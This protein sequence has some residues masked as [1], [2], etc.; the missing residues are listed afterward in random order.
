M[1]P[2]QD[3]RG[4][5]RMS[6]E[7]G[8]RA[9]FMRIFILDDE[10]AIRQLIRTACRGSVCEVHEFSRVDAAAAACVAGH[11][12]L[13]FLDL[14]LG[15]GDAIEA[16]RAF[17]EQGYAGP[18]QLMSGSGG[19]VLE[20][21]RRVGLSY[22]FDLLAPLEKPFR[23]VNIRGALA[24]LSRSSEVRIGISPQQDSQPRPTVNSVSL[25]EALDGGWLELWY[26]PKVDLRSGDIVG[27]EGLIRARH[28]DRGT[29]APAQFLP[30][31]TDSALK[32]LTELVI[33]GALRDWV[34]LNAAGWSL[35]LCVNTPPEA[36]LTLPIAE[37]LRRNRPQQP[38]WPGLILELTEDQA[39]QSI[40][41]AREIAAQLRI[42]KV[43]LS[44]DDF[45]Q[46]HSSLARLTEL[47]FESLKIDRAF[48][49]KCGTDPV[50]T[51]LCRTI[52]ELAHRFG[53]RVVAEGIETATELNA[54]RALGCDLGQGYLLG[55]P[56]PICNLISHLRDAR[57]VAGFLG[58]SVRPLAA[59][60]AFAS[61]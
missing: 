1:A 40:P 57:P 4:L 58:A 38:E 17:S 27:A 32:R 49:T 24:D 6:G 52:I 51:G 59:T 13:I 46:G 25:T 60:V 8:G 28:P 41:R 10:A 35:K 42:Q 11:P 14:D 22:G 30:G 44:L 5:R 21:V 55:R 29:L 50:Q 23:M 53:C 47:P 37:I 7:V 56:M 33:V 48:V 39:L 2:V 36:L 3:E 9:E 31:A 16:F 19:A 45:G 61:S 18:I 20:D 43:E 26:Q 12:D 15:T 54:L 34:T